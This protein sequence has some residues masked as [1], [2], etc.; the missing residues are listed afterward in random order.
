[1]QNPFRRSKAI[2]VT[3]AV[4][5]SIESGN[6]NFA[7]TLGTQ[8][9][10]ISQNAIREQYLLYESLEYGQLY[11][12]VPAVRTVVDFIARQ[13]VQLD[14]ELYGTNADGEREDVDD[15]PAAEFIDYPSENMPGKLWMQSMISD[16]LV[17][18]NSY[19]LKVRG[20]NG[21]WQ[22]FWI[23]AWKVQPYGES[24]FQTEGYKV[25]GERGSYE[26]VEFGDMIHWQDY[27]PADQRRGFSKLETLRKVLQEDITMQQT[28][29]E[30]MKSGLTGLGNAFFTLP[31]DGPEM[32]DEDMER[33]A[34]YLAAMTK[35]SGDVTPILPPGM[36][37]EQPNLS[38][39]KAQMLESRKFSLETVCKLYGVPLGL[40][41]GSIGEIEAQTRNLYQDVLPPLCDQIQGFMNLYVL[42]SEYPTEDLCYEFDLKSKLRGDNTARI[43]ANVS[44][45][46]GPYLTRNEVRVSEG[47][48]PLDEKG[49]DELIT[50]LNVLVGDK[51]KPSPA[52]MPVADPNGPAEDGSHRNPTGIP[53][54][55][56]EDPAGGKSS[57]ILEPASET[58][59]IAAEAKALLIARRRNQDRRR[60]EGADALTGVLSRHFSRQQASM[61]AKAAPADAASSER[62]NAELSSDLL[63]AFNSQVNHEGDVAA[64][65][66]GLAGFDMA[67]VKHYLEAKADNIAQNVNESTVEA[68]QA[69]ELTTA[70]VFEKAKS[71]RAVALGM[72]IATALS[73]FSHTEAAKQ[74][75]NVSQR[76][77]TW[78]VTSANSRHPELDGESVPL[79]TE[80]SNGEQMPGDGGDI[81]ET[82]GCQ[83]IVEVG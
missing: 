36:G 55:P 75:P 57:P 4:Q 71:D 9:G 79:Y 82:A 31:G 38:P 6:A 29:I 53:E 83:C 45:G 63:A 67:Q 70:E 12:Q 72:G 64:T 59:A 49:A 62:W 39:Q 14:F 8:L 33:T 47:L 18:G 76:M 74:D 42:K 5:Q 37:I 1:M 22:G 34:A 27:N 11:A 17:Y 66:L 3:P 35:K 52:V 51:P 13:I 80:F 26:Y 41:D 25:I 2:S 7:A 28:N 77:K 43:A 54:E 16:Y 15:H 19:T 58:K 32:T 48:P 61:M 24:I 69:K 10:K 21:G 23:P 20:P 81:S 40:I 56:S 50:P 73:S 68:L 46:G 60:N 30:L 65:R 44:S 78:I